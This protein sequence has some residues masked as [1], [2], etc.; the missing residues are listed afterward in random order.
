MELSLF[1]LIRLFVCFYV[2]LSLLFL[3]TALCAC[4]CCCLDVE[5]FVVHRLSLVIIPSQT[6]IGCTSRRKTVE[7][8]RQCY[9]LENIRSRPSARKDK[10]VETWG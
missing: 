3:V 2:I 4:F 10:M 6:I 5:M 9:P 8:K 1:S 7:L